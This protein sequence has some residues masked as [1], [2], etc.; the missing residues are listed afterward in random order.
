MPFG[1]PYDGY[2]NEVFCHAI[3]D[4]GLVP[5]RGDD[6]SRPSII[7]SDIW[8]SIMKCRIVL[9][10]LTKKNPNVFYELGIAHAIG[11]HA[12]LVAEKG[13]KLPFDVN[14]IRV[15]F[16]D[17]NHHDWGERLKLTVAKAI[18]E[19][20]ELPEPLGFLNYPRTITSSEQNNFLKSR[21]AIDIINRGYTL[22]M[23]AIQPTNL[24][25]DSTHAM[26]QIRLMV[27]SGIKDDHILRRCNSWGF[28]PKDIQQMIREAKLE[29][30]KRIKKIKTRAKIIKARRKNN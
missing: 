25:P 13:T 4:A 24:D 17:K 10:D 26:N 23:S 15:N 2:Y 20:L 9:A 5:E 21:K 28:P 7:I 11:R 30:K 12:V 18:K 16:F 29:F 22:G 27:L 1:S 14:S 8:N 6:L 3:R 19:A